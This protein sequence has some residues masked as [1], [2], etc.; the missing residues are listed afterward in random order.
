VATLA[1]AACAVGISAVFIETHQD[2]D[3]AP[4]DGPNMIDVADLQKLI[5]KLRVI[6]ELSKAI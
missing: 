6:D 3:N 4:C 2:P 5:E 1:R